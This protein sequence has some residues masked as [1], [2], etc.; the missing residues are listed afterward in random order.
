MNEK[1]A[2]LVNDV[3]KALQKAR[4]ACAQLDREDGLRGDVHVIGYEQA[5]EAVAD[6]LTRHVPGFDFDGFT[7]RCR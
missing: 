5:R 7:N 2:R 6:V 1:N 4:A 3:I